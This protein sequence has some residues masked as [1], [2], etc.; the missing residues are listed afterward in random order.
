MD[1]RPPSPGLASRISTGGKERIPVLDHNWGQGDGRQSWRRRGRHHSS[2]APRPQGGAEPRGKMHLPARGSEGPP[3]LSN[4]LLK[5]RGGQ[6]EHRAGP[7]LHSQT[8]C[9]SLLGPL[10]QAEG[11]RG[12][13]RGCRSCRGAW[14]GEAAPP[15]RQDSAFSPWGWGST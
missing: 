10:E 15:P 13:Q 11:N 6:P 8:L 12:L 4:K 5:A 3:K 9:S 14:R 2:C 1:K 7:S